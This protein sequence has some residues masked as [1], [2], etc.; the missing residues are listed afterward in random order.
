MTEDRVEGW[1][2]YTSDA[3]FSEPTL[4]GPV[5][6]TLT[7][8]QYAA[9]ITMGGAAEAQSVLLNSSDALHWVLDRLGVQALEQLPGLRPVSGAFSVA[10]ND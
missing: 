9:L 6:L 5:T 2:S 3:E 7:R 4:A 8:E 10:P 1:H